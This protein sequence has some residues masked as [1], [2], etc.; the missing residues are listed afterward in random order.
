M[1]YLPNAAIL[2]RL[3]RGSGQIVDGDKSIVY[4]HKDLIPQGKIL[5]G[6]IG[7]WVKQVWC[8]PKDFLYVPAMEID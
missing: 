4:S 7:W 5:Y 2:Y 6:A 3:A 1:S 8:L